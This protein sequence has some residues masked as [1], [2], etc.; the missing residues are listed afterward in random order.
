MGDSSGR[1]IS[2]GFEREAL[3]P[4]SASPSVASRAVDTV[5]FNIGSVER[6]ESQVEAIQQSMGVESQDFVPILYAEES[7]LAVEFLKILPTLAIIGIVAYGMRS[8]AKAGGPGGPGG[9]FKVGKSNHT[10]F[11][12]DEKTGVTFN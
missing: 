1:D 12:K 9:M 6:F 2:G 8:L 5:Q 4:A 11:G 3:P 7:N 10:K